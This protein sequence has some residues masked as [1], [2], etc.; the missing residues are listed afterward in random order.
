MVAHFK[1]KNTALAGNMKA[2]SFEWGWKERAERG[3]WQ[4]H[5]VVEAGLPPGLPNLADSKRQQLLV[6]GKMQAKWK[7]NHCIHTLDF[8]LFILLNWVYK[9]NIEH[10]TRKNILFFKYIM[11]SLLSIISFIFLLRLNIYKY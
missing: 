3:L 10:I 11:D 9:T 8:L 6:E 5:T 1:S 2:A 4:M 7:Q